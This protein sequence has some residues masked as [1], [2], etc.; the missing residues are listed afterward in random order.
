[1]R[2]V[3]HVGPCN[4]PGGMAKV[5]E[6][7]SQNPPEGW[8]AEILSSH[9]EGSVFAKLLAWCK[10]QRY[11]KI[12]AK[13]FDIIHIHSAAGWSY[14][15]KLKLAHI[16]IK[17]KTR[18]VF[19]IHS[20]QFDTFANTRKRIKK[21]LKSLNVVVLSNHWQKKL[22]PIIGECTVVSNPV[23]PNIIA[24]ESISRQLKQLLL[25]GRPD[26]V[27]GHNF[28]FDI[29]RQMHKDGWKLFA[30]GTKHCEPG[31]KGLGWIS[32]Q[33]KYRLLQESTALLIPSKFEGQPLVMLEALAAGCPV[34]ASDKIHEL[35]TCVTSATHENLDDWIRSIPNVSRIN[36]KDYIYSH[37][38]ANINVNWKELYSEII[39]N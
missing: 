14:R 17:Q 38:I 9:S 22:R 8:I 27:K 23:D 16:A 1:M 11:L 21:E 5:I 20:G 30:T 37:D 29:A 10:A 24:N 15:R 13:E 26:P 32:E 18:V 2:R 4:T 7:L 3:L 39:E 25:L 31:I 12:H 35:P 19:H 6:I 36:C 34:I 28:A 33:E